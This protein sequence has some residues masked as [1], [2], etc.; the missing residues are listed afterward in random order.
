M[1]KLVLTPFVDIENFSGR[2]V[3]DTFW[4]LAGDDRLSAGSAADIVYGQEGADSILGG[5]GGDRLYGHGVGQPDHP[6][7]P[8]GTL[9]GPDD[10][11]SDTLIG[12][13]GA[14]TLYGEGGN[15]R[16]LG[17]GVATADDNLADSIDGG[18]GNDTALGGGGA[19][20]IYGDTLDL[21]FFSPPPLVV[22]GWAESATQNG[23]DN[24]SGEAGDD[25]IYGAAGN[26]TIS[27]GTGV[28][29]INGGSGNDRITDTSVVTIPASVGGR[30]FGGTG[31]DTIIAGAGD[32]SLSG[33]ANSDLYSSLAGTTNGNDSLLGGS[34][35]DTITGSVRLT[36][37]SWVNEV[38]TLVGGAGADRFVLSDASGSLYVIPGGL[39]DTSRA[40]ITDFAVGDL[41]DVVAG[42][43]VVPVASGLAGVFQCNLSDAGNLVAEVRGASVAFG[44]SAVNV[45]N[46][47]IAA[48]I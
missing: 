25:V 44:G 34:G 8:P 26:D 19:D 13:A 2:T 48:L 31:S 11:A 42:V 35:N 10:N 4:L 36:A 21:V 47:V 45:Q 24:L 39:A 37:A 5:A 41:L 7:L 6:F 46:A 43:A 38:D 1:A 33:D 16:L 28:D 17:H 27:G 14:D 3:S 15:D 22:V 23:A 9:I 18:A 29:L 40:I 12:G 30:L 32:D 20:R